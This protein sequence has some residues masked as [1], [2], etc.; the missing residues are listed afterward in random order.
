MFDEQTYSG[1]D[2]EER[3]KYINTPYMKDLGIF[4]SSTDASFKSDQSI[5]RDLALDG[6]LPPVYS[7]PLVQPPTVSELMQVA[8][9][10]KKTMRE[11]LGLSEN[12]IG[13]T[14]HDTSVIHV[15]GDLHFGNP[16]T[17]N[18]RIAQELE[19]VKQT[20]NHYIM[21]IGDLV[22]GIWWGGA[23]GSEQA[24]TL[25]EQ[26][27]FLHGLFKEMRGKILV[28]MSGEHDC[29][30]TQT[31]AYTKRGWLNYDEI[32]DTDLFMTINPNTELLEWHKYTH[33]HKYDV[34]NLD[35]Y[36]IKTRD[37]D[38]LGTDNHRMFVQGRRNKMYSFI[39]A[40]EYSRHKHGNEF[41]PMA[42]TFGLPDM[43]I[44]DETIG[45]IAW[46]IADGWIEKKLFTKRIR[47]GQRDEK[48]YYISELLDNLKIKYSRHS[49]K[50][51]PSGDIIDGKIVKGRK[52]FS[53]FEITDKKYKNKLLD[54]IGKDKHILPKF[55]WKLSDR[56]FDIFLRNFILADG[57][58]NSRENAWLIFQKN[59]KFLDDLQAVCATHGLRSNIYTHKNTYG[60]QYR[61]N[62]CRR[63]G[64]R[65]N[66][67]SKISS[68]K[69]YTGTIWDI[70]VPNGN[71][72][73][74]RNDKSYFTGN[75][76]WAS[77]TGQD[78]YFMMADEA[79][80]PYIRGMAEISVDIG[81][82]QYNIVA[83]HRHRGHSMYNKNHPT[84]RT[85][86]FHL[87][88][89]DIY[90]SAHTHQKQISQEAIREFG[91]AR[92]VT[93]I[94]IGPYKTHDEYGDREGFVH[95]TPEEMY[96][97]SFRLHKDIKQVE[98]CNDILQAI[99]QWS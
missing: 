69:K 83:N 71:F 36:Q 61:L 31:Q 45:I 70:T 6:Q 40:S 93:H 63:T 49:V 99:K 20:P 89:G 28:G 72:L 80:A 5:K 29:V 87:Q 1:K 48:A 59:K 64:M 88:G 25:S 21:L 62:V 79:K 43:N 30:D 65:F 18:I 34:E 7:K 96:G 19:A 52:P 94:S 4:T 23:S 24:L 38:F 76:K 54:L 75:S 51:K 58:H 22:D 27:A 84:F 3:L 66:S 13:I 8:E 9:E 47:I 85:A 26:Y 12:Q 41:I 15:M 81:D 91:G 37:F 67:P 33:F 32:K 86:R 74:R 14:L 44:K 98:V 90:I 55:V 10:R 92:P 39:S 11:M 82:A 35:M 95:Q 97:A 57:T 50:V 17:D 56:Q 16:N 73:V 42:S 60:E 2:K 68:I 53:V 78:P 77:K 46:I